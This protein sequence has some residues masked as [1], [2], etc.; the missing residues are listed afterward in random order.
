MPNNENPIL[1]GGHPQIETFEPIVLGDCI[2]EKC[3]EEIYSGDF[4]E[5]GGQFFCNEYC[6]GRHLVNEGQAIDMSVR[7]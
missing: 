2:N 4:I 7:Y 6:L 5:F 1:S 3:N